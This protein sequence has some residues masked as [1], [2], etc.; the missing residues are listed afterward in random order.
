MPGSRAERA[1]KVRQAPGGI[2]ARFFLEGTSIRFRDR[3]RAT[4]K[5]KMHFEIILSEIAGDLETCRS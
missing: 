4:V 2:S 3:F 5:E 1:V